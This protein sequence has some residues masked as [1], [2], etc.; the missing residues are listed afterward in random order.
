VNDTAA[1]PSMLTDRPQRPGEEIGNAV[2]AAIFSSTPIVPYPVSTIG[3]RL[4]RVA[5]PACAGTTRPTH[6]GPSSGHG[7]IAFI[8]S[9]I[10]SGATSRV[11]VASD[12]LW[13]KGSTT[14]P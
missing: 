11:C 12:H 7:A 13:P 3:H 2:R 10:S 5:V 1:N 14:W 6:F 4:T 9:L 8:A